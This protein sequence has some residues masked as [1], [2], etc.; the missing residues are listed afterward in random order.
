MKYQKF[1]LSKVTMEILVCLLQ[2]DDFASSIARKTY[3]CQSHINKKFEELRNG[4]LICRIQK[5]HRK[6]VN[7]KIKY[8]TLTEKGRKLATQ[9]FQIDKVVIQG[10][11]NKQREMLPTTFKMQNS[12][13]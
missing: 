3:H 11:L 12:T 10:N 4:G 1:I 9:I 8:H 6:F 5:S 13:I 7:N 2:K